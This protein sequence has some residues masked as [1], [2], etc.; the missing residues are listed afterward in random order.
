MAPRRPQYSL[1]ARKHFFGF[2]YHYCCIDFAFMRGDRS[3][4][5]KEKNGERSYK[6][7]MSTQDESVKGRKGATR[8]R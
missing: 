7:P 2:T 4:C 3:T 8:I 5:P 1:D 6:E